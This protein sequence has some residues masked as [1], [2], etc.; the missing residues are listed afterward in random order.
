M[1]DFDQRMA[2]LRARFVARVC[3][4][5]EELILALASGDTAE[6]RRIGHGLSGAGG[7]VGFPEISAAAQQV[8]EAVDADCAPSRL[9]ALGGQLLNEMERVLQ[10]P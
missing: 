4:E 8:E 1:T 3:G 5:R 10:E 6:I 7:V 2:E 9:K